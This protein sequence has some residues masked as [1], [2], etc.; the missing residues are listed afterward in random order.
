MQSRGS[1]VLVLGCCLLAPAVSA[2]AL[3]KAG[4]VSEVK[5]R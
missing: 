1:T 3:D 2:Q 4:V 5:G